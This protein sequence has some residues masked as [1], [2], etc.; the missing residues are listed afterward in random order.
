[1]S[2][3]VRKKVIVVEE[4]LHEGGPGT[5]V[6]VP[7]THINATY[8]RGHFDAMEVCVPDAPQGHEL[9][10]SLVMCYGGRVHDR[11]GGLKAED[12]KGEDGLR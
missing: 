8:V 1:M 10:V 6:D 3:E 7:I 9:A 4:V 12:I 2:I 11:A 5:C